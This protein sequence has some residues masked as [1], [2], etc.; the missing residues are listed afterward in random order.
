M[1]QTEVRSMG[2]WIENRPITEFDEIDLW[3]ERTDLDEFISKIDR[4]RKGSLETIL[5]IKESRGTVELRNSA[6]VIDILTLLNFNEMNHFGWFIWH[7]TE[8][9]TKI[10]SQLTGNSNEIFGKESKQYALLHQVQQNKES[11]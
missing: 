2:R 8:R 4:I 10:G 9:R 5:P 7:Q 6:A 3:T 11:W 1:E